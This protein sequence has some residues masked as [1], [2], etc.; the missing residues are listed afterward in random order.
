[1]KRGSPADAYMNDK[2][3]RIAVA[4]AQAI[5]P[6][7]AL[8]D[9]VKATARIAMETHRYAAEAHNWF[10]QQHGSVDQQVVMRDDDLAHAPHALQG[11]VGF[12]VHEHMHA[13]HVGFPLIHG[14]AAVVA[15]GQVLCNETEDAADAT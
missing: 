12:H 7:Q 11:Q 6:P 4:C 2:V 8:V 13:S 5:A 9:E 1:M 3:D 10:M 14:A 15:G